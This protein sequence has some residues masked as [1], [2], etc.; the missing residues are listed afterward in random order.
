MLTLS[1]TVGDR[2]GDG[3]KRK[4]FAEVHK[5]FG[6]KL[7]LVISGGA[8]LNKTH[9]NG[10]R[11]LGFTIV[12]GYGLTETFGP[13]TV[14]PG[15]KPR[16]G[17]VGPVLPENEIKIIE[18]DKAG[19]GEVLLRG[20]CVFGGYYRND[21]LTREVIDRDG[22]FHTGDLGK[23]DNEGYLYLMGRK[24]DVIVLD[25]GKNVYPD[26]LEDFYGTS[27]LIEEIGVFGIK[28]GSNEIVAA[29]IVPQASMRRS[30]SLD[31]ISELLHADLVRLGKSMPVYRRITDFV[32]TAT[33]LPRTTTRKL[34]KNDLRELYTSLK[35]KNSM[36]TPGRDDLS[37]I[38][39]ALMES[40]EYGAVIE[41]IVGIN[42][43]NKPDKITL[44]SLFDADLGLDSLDRLE[45]HNRLEK[46]FSI[47]IPPAVF[48]KAETV[49]DVVMM[50]RDFTGHN[51]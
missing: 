50:V 20:S 12:E 8:A 9:W 48:D 16:L 49:G 13:I 24:K 5:G 31:K 29:A 34:K 19:I 22:W 23:L 2:L 45:L 40:I 32:V 26:E 17:S 6:G 38:E 51:G 4:L 7:R 21:V 27:P 42:S 14:C 33:P 43:T 15:E 35:Q 47:I 46:H 1:A 28:Q 3:F 18:V 10:F 36:R 30:K 37:V 41:C 39:L 44:R 25:S 11:R